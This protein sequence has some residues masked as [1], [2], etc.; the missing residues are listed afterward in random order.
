[1]GLRT[2]CATEQDHVSKQ[3]S[4]EVNKYKLKMKTGKVSHISKIHFYKLNPPPSFTFTTYKLAVD[5]G[6]EAA[7]GTQ[8]H[9]LLKG[10]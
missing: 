6:D 9:N 1:M 7:E 8:S 4:K 3:V 2:V 5:P 10:R